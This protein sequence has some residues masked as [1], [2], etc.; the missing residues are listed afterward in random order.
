MRSPR[1]AE[2][3]TICLGSPC[4]NAPSSVTATVPQTMP[5]T[6]RSVRSFWL[7]M[8]LTICRSA[9]LKLSISSLALS[10][11]CH[12]E[13]S[14]GSR[15]RPRRSRSFV[16]SLLRMTGLS[17]DLLGRPFY[18]F[19][20]L[21]KT[22]EDFRVH[23]VGDAEL[24]L[25]SLGPPLRIGS[26]NL[27][28]G[29]LAAVLEGHDALGH[30]HDVFLFADDDVGV[31]GV[32]G[33]QDDR[34]RLLELDLDV[35]E[36]RSFLLLRLGRD[37]RDAACYHIGRERSDLDPGGQAH[38][39]FSD[40]DLVHGPL[41]D[42]VAHVGDRGE[43]RARLVGGQGCYGIAGIHGSGEH[44]PGGRRADDGLHGDASPGDPPPAR[45]LAALFGPGDRDL[46]ELEGLPP[47]VH[48]RLWKETL[49][50]ELLRTSEVGLRPLVG[51]P[52]G[53][54]RAGARRHTPRRRGA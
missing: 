26:R 24:D 43:L 3:L 34:A 18:D 19:R 6:V 50:N 48:V 29:L 5:K 21:L 17:A 37:P 22:R 20:A 30:D 40:V 4:P 7:R 11:P 52:G 46:R 35:E 45:Q 49:A 38:A 8:S 33:A 15:F 1:P 28:E 41:E 9:S 47:R 27:D 39:E 10:P 12:P 44:R 31:G 23:A 25:D 32:P 13:R 14:E 16:A 53:G 51:R 36:R 2:F 54:G 42:Q